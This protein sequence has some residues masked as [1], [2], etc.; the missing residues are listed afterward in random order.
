MNASLKNAQAIDAR[1]KRLEAQLPY[2]SGKAQAQIVAQIRK[3][4]AARNVSLN[5]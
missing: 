3:L 4:R 1:M 2:S 5:A